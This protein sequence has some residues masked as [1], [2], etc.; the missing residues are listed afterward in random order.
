MK[1]DEAKEIIQ[2]AT[3]NNPNVAYL[4]LAIRTMLGAL[5]K[6]GTLPKIPIDY[7]FGDRNQRPFNGD[8]VLLHKNDVVVGYAAYDESMRCF[9]DLFSLKKHE[10]RT[11]CRPTHYT[12]MPQFEEIQS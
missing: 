11:T 4:G 9:I 10:V 1:L 7:E 2:I 12:P 5:D 6:A 8:G 3:R